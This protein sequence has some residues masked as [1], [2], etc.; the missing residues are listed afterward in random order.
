MTYYD[1][2]GVL[3]VLLLVISLAIGWWAFHPGNKERF[4]DAANLPFAD[5][6]P[7]TQEKHTDV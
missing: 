6:V 7:H 5:D 3:S 4:E 1:W 2:L